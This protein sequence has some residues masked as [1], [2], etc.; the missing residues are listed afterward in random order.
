MNVNGSLFSARLKPTSKGCPLGTSA[1]RLISKNTLP[2]GKSSFF[3]ISDSG[4]HS[5]GTK[6]FYFFKSWLGILEMENSSWVLHVQGVGRRVGFKCVGI[7]AFIPWFLGR[8]H[9][10]NGSKA[11]WNIQVR[12]RQWIGCPGVGGWA[13]LCLVQ[14]KLK[15]VTPSVPSGDYRTGSRGLELHSE[16]SCRNWVG[17]FRGEGFLSWLAEL[18]VFFRLS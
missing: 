14:Y 15:H 18:R 2:F 10:V 8:H 1:E 7:S 12:L 3:G 6:T 16:G 11:F 13:I 9:V 5:F 4:T 17:G